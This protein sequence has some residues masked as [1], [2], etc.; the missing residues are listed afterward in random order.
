MESA[1]LR[2][3]WVA[4]FCKVSGLQRRAAPGRVSAIRPLAEH[5]RPCDSPCSRNHCQVCAITWRT[6]S[7]RPWTTALTA[8]AISFSRPA[9]RPAPGQGNRIRARC[10]RV[11]SHRSG[12]QVHWPLRA[13][14][15]I[16]EDE[17]PSITDSAGN[18]KINCGR[19]Q[20][21]PVPPLEWTPPA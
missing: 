13:R 20:P 11:V 8:T 19:L 3:N 21:R 6:S 16:A 17:A 12:Q 10:Q 9:R 14:R 18:Q 2:L 15:F 7:A 1:L 5:W 4:G